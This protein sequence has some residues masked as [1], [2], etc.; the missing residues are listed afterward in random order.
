[1]KKTIEFIYILLA[2]VIVSGIGFFLFKIIQIFITNLD[3]VNA[4]FFIAI[5]GATVT[6]TGYFLTRYFERKKIIEMDIRNKKIPIYEEFMKFYFQN[7]YSSKNINKKNANH[8]EMVHFFQDFH[9]K[10]IVWFP[11]EVLKSYI[12]WK[13]NISK[14]SSGQ[15][16]LEETIL[17]QENFM[18]IIRKDIGHKNKDI[19][20]WD[21]SSLYINDLENIINKKTLV[22]SEKT[23]AES[24]KITP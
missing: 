3:K 6:F 13:K 9:Q 15:L 19:E 17:Q 2:I 10:A 23:N 7:I 11:D 16:E 12:N 24:S 8:T 20:K 21:I 14:F 5:L 18:K 22:D 1:M 4:N